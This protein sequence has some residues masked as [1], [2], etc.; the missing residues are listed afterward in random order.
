MR[1]SS[2]RIKNYRSIQDAQVPLTDLTCLVGANNEGK[3]N[4]L[5]AAITATSH[6]LGDYRNP[7]RRPSRQ[8]HH[9]SFIPERDLPRS[10]SAA[11]PTVEI[12]LEL[13]EEECDSFQQELGHKINGEL[14]IRV[15]LMK[16]GPQ[17][18]RVLKQKSGGAL[19]EKSPEIA[20]FIRQRLRLEYIPAVRTADQAVDVVRRLV[21]DQLRTLRRNPEYREALQKLAEIEQPLLSE[22]EGDL[23]HSL[24]GFLHDLH[25]V[26]IDRRA[27]ISGNPGAGFDLLLDDGVSTSLTE[28]GDGVQSLA[29]IAL[30]RRAAQHSGAHDRHLILAIEEPETHLHPAAVRRLRAV[31]REISTEQQVILTTHSPLLIDTENPATNIVVEDQAARPADRVADIREC[32]GVSVADNLQSARLVVLVEGSTDVTA[33]TSALSDQSSEIAKFLESGEIV[34]AALGGAS[35]LST[36]ATAMRSTA[37]SVFVVLDS[38]DAGETA[39]TKAIDSGRISMSDYKLLKRPR[40]QSSELEDLVKFAAYKNDIEQQFKM[41]FGSA[42]SNGKGPKWSDKVKGYLENA[43]RLGNE[44]ELT[45]AKLIVSAAVDSQGLGALNADGKR[46]IAQLA[47][48]L[49]ER[50]S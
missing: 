44:A 22:I 24:S 40:M 3:S 14:K 31:L 9:L 7:T 6:M 1:I 20:E 28:K 5:R 30:A 50:L 12:E 29:A 34:L 49:A 27:S 2:F 46:L 33:L 15:S 18:V 36:Q 23:L 17:G 11:R 35:H 42:L 45:Q 41:K 13:D 32:L 39:L 43:G 47:D 8:T 4:I 10:D 21:G 19:T 26:S 16:P 37:C 48:E 38:D 25:S